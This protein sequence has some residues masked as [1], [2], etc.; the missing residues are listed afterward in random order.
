MRPAVFR[1]AR[2]QLSAL[3]YLQNQRPQ[4][5]PLLV[6]DRSYR[7]MSTAAT[8]P[9]SSAPT[10]QPV[11]TAPAAKE[12]VHAKQREQGQKKEKKV[13]PAGQGNVEIE[14]SPPPEFFD[15][16]N[17]IFDK[18]KKIYDDK[19][20]GE[21]LTCLRSYVAHVRLIDVY[22]SQPCPGS[23]SLSLSQTVNK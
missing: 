16:R 6:F 23:P 9:I 14:L 11:E 10:G 15:S 18:Y 3:R 7:V 20:A 19:V 17:A 22:T 5:P 8:H 2:T 4:P 1:T 21:L 13:K 12:A